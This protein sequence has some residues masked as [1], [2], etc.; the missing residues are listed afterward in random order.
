MKGFARDL[1]AYRSTLG[2]QD[3][4]IRTYAAK[5]SW[6]VNPRWMVYMNLR[7]WLSDCEAMY[8]KRFC[9]CFEPSGDAAL[10]K[11]L[12]CPCEFAQAE[13]DGVGWCHCTLFGRADLTPADYARA[14]ASLMAEYRD[15]PLKWVEGV[16]DTRGQHIEELRGLPVPDAIHQVKRALNGKGAPIRAIVASRTEADH[17]ERLAEM[18]GLAFSRNQAELGYLVELG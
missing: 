17:L 6:S 3:T 16:L 13:I 12:I 4:W 15:V 9:P 8:G 11:K 14:E 1:L 10:D 7:L 18:R 2:R 5:K